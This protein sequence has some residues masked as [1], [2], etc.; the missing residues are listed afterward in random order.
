VSLSVGVL[1]L[2][3]AVFAGG[4]GALFRGRSERAM[5]ALRAFA[6]VAAVSMALLHLV[7]EAFGEVGWRALLAAMVGY[8]A[9]AA[10][11]R[12]IP[13]RRHGAPTTAL[14][15]GYAAVLAHQLGE[16]AA[17]ASL[18][19]VG[20]LSALLLLAIAAHTIPLAMVVAIRVLEV[21]GS[22]GG[23]RAMGLALAGVALATVAGALAGTLLSA[24]RVEAVEPW[25]IA[26]VAG[27][28]LHAL[29][30]EALASKAATTGGRV[31][32]A[33]AGLLGLGLAA[34]GVERDGWIQRISPEL[35]ALGVVA[36]A[37]LIIAR[38]FAPARLG[39]R[40]HAHRH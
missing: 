31:T 18:A 29:S 36:L 10:L 2:A 22:P 38:S 35:R 27:I 19:R 5:P 12:L 24:G 21:K 14:A 11:E 13:S 37:A 32:E 34:A 16:G 1:I 39:A 23:K 4:A 9:P 40:P 15:L 25:V 33:L 8:F 30:H 6:V 17:V 26:T 7:P 3:L 28:L 20:S